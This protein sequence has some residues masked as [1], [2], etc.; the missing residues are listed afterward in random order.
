MTTAQPF[1]KT[2]PTTNAPWYYDRDTQT[3]CLVNVSGKPELAL[4]IAEIRGWGWISKL[5]SAE[6]IQDANGELIAEAGNVHRRTGK[7]PEELADLVVRLSFALRGM[8]DVYGTIC[9]TQ[10][11]DRHH[12]N[13]Y[14]E[15]ERLLKSLKEFKVTA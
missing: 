15:G 14:S 12:V 4:K 1:N 9:D 5:P 3:V 2:Q 10:G 7:T 6:K 11:W 8:M 13:Q